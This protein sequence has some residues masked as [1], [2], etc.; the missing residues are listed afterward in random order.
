M[1][2]LTDQTD[3]EILSSLQ[4]GQ[5]KQYT[6]D[7]E[8]DPIRAVQIRQQFLLADYSDNIRDTNPYKDYSNYQT[9]TKSCCENV[10]GYVPVPLGLAG[11]LLVNGRVYNVPI[12]TTEGALVASLSRGCRAVRE[13]C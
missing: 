6:L 2:Q 3:E 1:S 7:R 12:A 11:P 9:A 5:I 8:L 4:T 13:R 10:I